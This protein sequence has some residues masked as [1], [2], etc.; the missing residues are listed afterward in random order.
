MRVEEDEEEVRGLYQE[1]QQRHASQHGYK[2][3]RVETKYSK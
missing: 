3:G 2:R 1:G